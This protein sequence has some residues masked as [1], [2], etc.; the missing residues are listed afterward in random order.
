MTFTKLLFIALCSLL[1]GG[2]STV[3]MAL[4]AKSK[5]S[6]C[7]VSGRWPTAP[8]HDTFSRLFR[9]LDPD[10]F[11]TAFQRFIASARAAT[12]AWP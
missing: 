3:D 11:R 1:C 5:E 10:A 6:F 8:S 12:T 7:A 4:F 2:Q 9:Q